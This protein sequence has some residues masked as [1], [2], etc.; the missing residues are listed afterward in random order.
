MLV[1]SGV[2]HMLRNYVPISGNCA[3]QI[4]AGIKMVKNTG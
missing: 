3:F 2:R 4:I 1:C